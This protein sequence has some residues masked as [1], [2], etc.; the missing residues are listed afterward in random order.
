MTFPFAGGNRLPASGLN[1]LLNSAEAISAQAL[2]AG[3]SETTTSASFVNCAGTG[4]ITSFSWTKRATN[5]AAII[6]IAA[7]FF[8]A[9]ANAGVRFGLLI[10]GT[11][12]ELAGGAPGTSVPLDCVGFDVVTGI[13]A[14]IYTVQARWRRFNGAGTPTRN[15]NHWMSAF[16]VEIPSP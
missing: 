3:S 14:G 9:T 15:E 6:G 10:N 16:A 5:T 2:G 13:P 8:P 7:S 4:A 1:A 11:D 12:Y